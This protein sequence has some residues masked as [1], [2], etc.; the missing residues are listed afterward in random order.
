MTGDAKRGIRKCFPEK[1]NLEK[2]G[3]QGKQSVQAP[4]GKEVQLIHAARV[5]LLSLEIRKKSRLGMEMRF[6]RPDHERSS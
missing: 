1:E 2:G 3:M 6:Q 4:R 5:R